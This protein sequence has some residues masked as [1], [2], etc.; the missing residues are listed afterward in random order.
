MVKESNDLT[1]ALNTFHDRLFSK[2]KLKNTKKDAK[3]LEDLLNYISS[4]SSDN[5]MVPET[6]QDCLTQINL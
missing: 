2:F 5:M 1:S 6:I 4:P 3:I